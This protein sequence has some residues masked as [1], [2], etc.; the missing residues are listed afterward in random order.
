MTAI[1]SVTDG[2]ASAIERRWWPFRAKGPIVQPGCVSLTSGLPCKPKSGDPRV[3][4]AR[5]ADPDSIERRAALPLKA[6]PDH[7]G[8]R[9]EP[10][11]QGGLPSGLIRRE[12][13]VEAEH[14]ASGPGFLPDVEVWLV[15]LHAF[16]R[17]WRHK[18]ELCC[19]NTTRVARTVPARHGESGINRSAAARWIGLHRTAARSFVDRAR[20]QPPRSG[21]RRNPLQ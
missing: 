8:G 1:K 14:G 4:L 12:R 16:C 18:I 6:S 15:G 5:G 2:Q 20:F 19:G 11:P 7:E 21:H 3:Q 13:L 17:V 9:N 10:A